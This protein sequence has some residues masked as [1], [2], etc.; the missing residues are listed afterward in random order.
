MSE[1]NMNG[2]SMYCDIS[3]HSL[4]HPCSMSDS[5]FCADNKK[6]Y[7]QDEYSRMPQ[8]HLRG[9]GKWVLPLP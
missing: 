3:P 6:K 7:S 1:E 8:L 4:R 9:M 2:Y 5:F